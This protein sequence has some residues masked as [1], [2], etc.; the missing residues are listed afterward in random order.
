MTK[1]YRGGVPPYDQIGKSFLISL[2]FI[3][4]A[5][6]IFYVIYHIYNLIMQTSLTTYTVLR[7]PT[8]VYTTSSP[9]TILADGNAP[10]PINGKEFSYSFWM[11]VENF[12]TGSDKHVFSRGDNPIFVMDQLANQLK[13]YIAINANATFDSRNDP[14]KYK[15]IIVDYIPIQRWVNIV[16]V[17]DNEFLTVF[18]D[19]DIN[20]VINLESGQI[21]SNTTGSFTIASRSSLN[22]IDGIMSNIKFFNYAVTVNDARALYASGPTNKNILTLMGLPL[23]GVRNPFYRIDTVDD[24]EDLDGKTPQKE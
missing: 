21:V 13:I 23:Y 11:Y 20:S 8:R 17:V 15:M 14:T 22:S 7:T 9:Y 18:L 19:G 16:L 24:I 3:L 2:A 4:L 6:L 5:F 10:R 1:S 12:S